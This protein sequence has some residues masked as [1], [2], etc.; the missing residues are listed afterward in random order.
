LRIAEIVSFKQLLPPS[1]D[2]SVF[3]AYIYT[4]LQYPPGV[5]ATVDRIYGESQNYLNG[6]PIGGNGLPGGGVSFDSNGPQALSLQT[7][8]PGGGLTYG[9][10][11]S[12]FKRFVSSFTSV[13]TSG[14]YNMAGRPYDP[15]R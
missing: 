12:I 6:F 8:T 15:N 10:D 1:N 4:G 3:T 13:F 2:E 5:D 11:V 14:F 7:G 9:A